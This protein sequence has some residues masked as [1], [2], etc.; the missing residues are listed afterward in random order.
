M[1]LNNIL[2]IKIKSRKNYI[3]IVK[4]KFNNEI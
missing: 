1:V 3:L 2:E 4:D